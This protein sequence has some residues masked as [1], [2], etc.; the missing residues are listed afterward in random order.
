MCYRVT[1]HMMRCD[2]RPIISNGEVEIVNGYSEPTACMCGK[3]DDIKERLRCDW[4]GCCRTA[5]RVHLCEKAGQCLTVPFHRYF[6]SRMEVEADDW[7]GSIGRDAPW[8]EMFVLDDEHIPRGCQT[9]G[10]RVEYEQP[11][12]REAMKEMLAIGQCIAQMDRMAN[13]VQTNRK[14]LVELMEHRSNMYVRLAGRYVAFGLAHRRG[15][16]LGGESG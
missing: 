4:H 5:T 12:F 3:Q 15:S 13:Q 14:L 1:S 16:H 11:T 6:Q 10:S 9:P 8:P 7:S 2:A